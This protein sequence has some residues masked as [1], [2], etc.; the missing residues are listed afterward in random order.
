MKTISELPELYRRLAELRRHDEENVL[1]DAFDRYYTPEG[2]KFWTCV[3]EATTIKELPPIPAQSLIDLGLIEKPRWKVEVAVLGYFAEKGHLI[4][5][6]RSD[7]GLSRTE[8]EALAQR[9]NDA[10]I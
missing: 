7:E 8:A 10:G 3:Y 4:L 6:S 5:R 1:Y 2:N 9:L